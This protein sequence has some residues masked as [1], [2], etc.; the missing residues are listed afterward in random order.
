MAKSSRKKIEVK[1]SESNTYPK[2]AREVN[3]KQAASD[4]AR[5][6]EKEVAARTIEAKETK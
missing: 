2:N 5:N 3:F 4:A 6:H 1:T